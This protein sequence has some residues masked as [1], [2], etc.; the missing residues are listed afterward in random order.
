M[1]RVACCGGCSP[2]ACPEALP[3]PILLGEYFLDQEEKRPVSPPL[4]EAAGRYVDTSASKSRGG[5]EGGV[6]AGTHG[7]W[8][9]RGDFED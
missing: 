3:T 8:I 6:V 5:L 4:F 1:P 2:A 9:G 7:C